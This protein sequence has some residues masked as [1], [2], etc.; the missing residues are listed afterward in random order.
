MDP[1]ILKRL[2][3]TNRLLTLW[4]AVVTVLLLLSLGM[5]A[6][7]VQAANDP[8]VRVFT[9]T[10]EDVG[11]G[12][13]QGNYNPPLVISSEST[14]T[15]LA[16]KTVTLSTNHVHTCLVTA[17]AEIDRSQD[18]NALLQFTLTMDST[19]GVANKPAHRRVEFDTYASDREDYEEVTTMLG[20]DNVSGTHTFR[21]LGR[22]NVGVSASA[23]VSAAS[24]VIACFKKL[25]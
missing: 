9:A 1:Q 5:N 22:R 11:G 7:W 16:E 15:I 17:S 13:A 3:R 8:P 12:H 24:M 20:F 19:N 2:V 4:L 18:A 6:A 23:N 21:F 14:A 25:L 10:L